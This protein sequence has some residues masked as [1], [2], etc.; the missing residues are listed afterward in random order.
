MGCHTFRKEVQKGSPSCIYPWRS[1]PMAMIPYTK[2]HATSAQRIMHLRAKGLIISHP[3]VAAKKI[4]AIGY[5]R[6]RIYFLSRRQHAVAGKPFIVGTTYQDIINLYECDMR[7]RNACFSSVGYFELLLRNAISEVLSQAHGSHPYY[8][9]SAYKNAASNLEALQ[10]FARVYEKSKD[11]RA[12]HYRQTYSSPVMP[13]VWTMKEF[14]TFGSASYLYQRLEGTLRTSIAKQ[15]GVSSDAVFKS[16]IE[17]LVDLRN[18]CAHHD[19][20]FNRTFQ[21]QPI[22]L[23]SA[24]VPTARPNKLKAILQCLDY[25]LQQRGVKSKITNEVQ[26]IIIRFPQMKPAEAGY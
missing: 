16:W 25:M 23:Q 13:P 1:A 19:R 18:I 3:N 4:E 15:F 8:D 24:S 9:E 17:C 2:L 21:K 6:L 12:N 11:G 22:P 26:D 20:L 10:T 7:L 14:L 5:E